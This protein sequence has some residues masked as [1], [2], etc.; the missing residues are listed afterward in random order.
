MA[1]LKI[2]RGARIVQQYEKIKNLDETATYAELERNTMDF[3]PTSKKRQWAIDPVNILTMELIPARESQ[4]LMIQSDVNSDGKIYNQ[5]IQFRPVIFEDSDQYNNASFVG[6]DKDEYHIIP[7]E[8]NRATVKVHC[9]CLDFYWRFA[10]TDYTVDALDGTPPPPYNATGRRPPVN[11][12][13]VPGV[14]KHL[15]KVVNQ[16]KVSGVVS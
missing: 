4:T 10:S 9:T 8:L 2:I 13:G 3:I 1:K 16:L 11:P 12:R 5:K 15:L 6:P 7:I 14:C